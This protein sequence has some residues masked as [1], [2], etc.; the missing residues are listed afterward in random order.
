MDYNST[1]KPLILPE[2]GR[3]IHKMVD[4]A[5]TIE[6]RNERTRCA[7]SIV[8]VMGNLFPHLRDVS[9]FKHKLWD[10]IAIMSDFELDIDYPYEP[11][12]PDNFSAKPDPVPYND[13]KIH[14]RHYGRLIEQMIL[15]AIDMEEGELKSYFVSLIANHMRKS[16]IN[17]NKDHANDERIKIDMETLSGGKLSPTIKEI[18]LLDN[19]DHHNPKGGR[20][21]NFSRKKQ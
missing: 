6:D 14:Y 18:R 19:R 7:H 21:R 20:R 1:R 12:R 5:K 15:K 9:D 16:L 11:P 17:W 13:F 2:Y 10:H 3:H 8:S 4:Y